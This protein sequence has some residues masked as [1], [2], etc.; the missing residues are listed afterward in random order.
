MRIIIKNTGGG[1]A[2]TVLADGAGVRGAGKNVGPDGFR[3]S[4]QVSSQIAQFLRAGNA[5][6]FN[7]GNLRTSIAFSVRREFSSTQ[8]AEFWLLNHVKTVQREDTL[9]MFAQAE[10]GNEIQVTVSD[11]VLTLTDLQ[12]EGVSVRVS[13]Q[14]TGGAI[15]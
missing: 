15:S 6:V 5:K 4:G 2:Q 12:H 8:A 9:Y 7:R 10:S 13:Y 14:I 3:I 1:N 11:C